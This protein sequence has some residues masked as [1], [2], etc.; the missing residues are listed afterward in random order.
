MAD[1]D[2][3]R[4]ALRTKGLYGL[5]G[6]ET[7]PTAMSPI[8]LRMICTVRQHQG[9]TANVVTYTISCY[10]CHR[11][12]LT[13]ATNQYL[14]LP[15]SF[16]LTK[17]P[18]IGSTIRSVLLLV[19]NRRASSDIFCVSIRVNDGMQDGRGSGNGNHDEGNNDARN[20]FGK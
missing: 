15:S 3:S 20:H 4:R 9:F 17:N 18:M 1:E 16:L 12:N 2:D 19:Q 14:F 8:S 7:E 13:L 5:H 6:A 11:A 10:V